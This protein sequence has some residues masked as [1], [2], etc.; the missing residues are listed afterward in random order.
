MPISHPR[1]VALVSLAAGL[2]VAG[3]ALGSAPVGAAPQHTAI[4]PRAAVTQ[5]ALSHVTVAPHST[6]AWAIGSQ[7]TKKGVSSSYALR[8]VGSHWSKVGI[9]IAGTSPSL[10]GLAAGSAKSV[11]LVGES[12]TS[13]GYKGFVLHS[14][15]SG[16][17]PMKVKA[18]AL[19][20]NLSSVSASSAS[21]A[22][23]V[24]TSTTG[25]LVLH[26]NGHKWAAVKIPTAMASPAPNQVSTSSPSNVWLSSGATVLHWNGHKFSEVPLMLP[27]EA[28]VSTITTGSAK[29]VWLAGTITTTRTK[30]FILHGNGHKWTRVKSPSPFYSSYIS[31]IATAGS[32]AYV[33]GYGSGKTFTNGLTEKS[34][35]LRFAGGKWHT[36]K[37]AQRGKYTTLVSVG[38]SSKLAEA[39]GTWS[40]QPNCTAK[41][42]QEPLAETL[43]GG[44]WHLSPTPKIHASLNHLR[45]V[46][47]RPNRPAC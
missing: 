38:V 22:W 15:G 8:R 28:G 16:F 14:K 47:A 3:V 24:G 6:K 13:S 29:N 25:A 10:E 33:V 20:S 7:Y 2:V 12:L 44:S 27:T 42:K 31:S 23:A 46:P 21:N 43:S 37:V 17:K 39:V 18:L 40:S 34:F 19:G 30:T 32:H 45:L 9:K 4:P 11:W 36:E 35:A 5:A 1:R 41:F 26:Y